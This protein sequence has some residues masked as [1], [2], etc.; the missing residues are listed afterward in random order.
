M[1]Y[2]VRIADSFKKQSAE[3]LITMAGFAGKRN[4]PEFRIKPFLTQSCGSP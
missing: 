4:V 3:Q 1:L 2:P